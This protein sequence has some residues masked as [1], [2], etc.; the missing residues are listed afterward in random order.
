MNKNENVVC[1]C[2]NI[3]FLQDACCNVD[4][5]HHIKNFDLSTATEDNPIEFTDLLS[6]CCGYVSIRTILMADN[7]VNFCCGRGS[8]KSKIVDKV[9]L[10]VLEQMANPY[11]KSYSR[12]VMEDVEKLAQI[13]C[14]N[15]HRHIDIP[16]LMHIVLGVDPAYPGKDRMIN[17]KLVF[18]Q[19]TNEDG[20]FTCVCRREDDDGKS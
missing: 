7:T 8:L 3:D 11:G 2:S 18:E 5:P 1:E 12:C 19:K 13:D 9:I 4:C 6:D 15:D 16:A 17:K 20:G 14:K 10:K